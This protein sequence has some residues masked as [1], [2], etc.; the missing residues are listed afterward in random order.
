MPKFSEQKSRHFGMTMRMPMPMTMTMTMKIVIELI[1]I[2]LLMSNQFAIL[3]Q[4]EENEDMDQTFGKNHRKHR[5]R[6]TKRAAERAAAEKLAAQRSRERQQ[7]R[8]ILVF[9][10][11][12]HSVRDG[13]NVQNR[14]VQ[15]ADSECVD[16][17]IRLTPDMFAP[18]H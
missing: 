16:Q 1:H 6:A 3:A 10:R 11:S 4:N 17:L 13:E 5:F 18:L 14:F 12:R 15:H 2:I 8:V 7:N 9:D